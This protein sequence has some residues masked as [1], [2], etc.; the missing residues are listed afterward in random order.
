M[1]TNEPT[2]Q[3]PVKAIDAITY[4]IDKSLCYAFAQ[5]WKARQWAIDHDVSNREAWHYREMNRTREEGKKKAELEDHDY[6]CKT[7]GDKCDITLSELWV[8]L[9][10]DA[11]QQGHDE[12]YREGQRDALHK[13]ES[14]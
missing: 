11:H 12:G 14:Q 4:A 2:P 10:S 5:G 9:Q 1:M 6:V 8:K 7:H 3:K 13:G